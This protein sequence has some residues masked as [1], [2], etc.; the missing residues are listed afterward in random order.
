MHVVVGGDI[1]GAERVV[2]D[3][4]T[5]A[6][7]TGADHHVALITPNRALAS[8]F[9]NA[10][11]RVHD[12]GPARES[13]L[14]YLYRSLGPADV[15]WLSERLARDAIDVVHTHTFG[16]HVIGTRA[17]RRARRPQLRTE[18]H[19]MH[20]FDASSSA[21]TRWAAART[22]RFVAVS[23]YVKR[24]LAEAA[25]RL[26]DRM[27]VVRNGVDTAYFSPRDRGEGDF[28]LGVVCRLTGW[29]R[30]HLAI[31]AAALSGAELVVIGDGEE[32]GRL[33]AL[34]RARGAR[35]RFVGFQTDPRAF[36]AACD[37]ILSTADSEPLGLSVLE[38][39]A[40]ARPVIAFATGGIPEIV[41]NEV[42]GMLVPEATAPA[43]AQ[44]I[45]RARRDRSS[46]ERMGASARRFAVDHCSIDR[47]CQ[48]YAAAYEAVSKAS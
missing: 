8:Y 4:A 46:L 39:L 5:R 9:A 13:P 38:A 18:H 15:A 32:R 41:E 1:G 20:Y 17:A 19:V 42:T 34:A 45:Q 22:E 35:V 28:C 6:E 24:V 16:S 10:G 37:A 2:A 30:V 40:M 27:T 3:L 12:R 48:G 14:A 31:E 29:K 7:L 11:V 36:V 25:P 26:S 33:E 44:V 21:F 43:L 47:M 23:E